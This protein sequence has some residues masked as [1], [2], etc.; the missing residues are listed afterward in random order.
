VA[1]L[2]Q[3][4]AELTSAA[5]ASG[6]ELAHCQQQL[7]DASVSIQDLRA[8]A[9]SAHPVTAGAG[10]TVGGVATGAVAGTGSGGLAAADGAM[11]GGLN[12][13]GAGSGSAMAA[14]V[15]RRQAIEING[16]TAQPAIVSGRP[17]AGSSALPAELQ[18]P[19]GTAGQQQVLASEMQ[20]LPVQQA[21][22]QGGAVSMQE[23]EEGEVVSSPI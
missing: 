6:K 16:A 15:A 17:G 13:A 1:Q 19:M 11:V 8:K 9:G 3:R 23:E 4:V 22:A 18:R 2:R 14:E 5:E 10:G 21:R 12:R 20:E 7:H